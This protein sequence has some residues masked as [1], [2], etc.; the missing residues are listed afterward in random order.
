MRSSKINAE[1]TKYLNTGL[2]RTRTRKWVYI[3]SA[4]FNV[5]CCPPD[6]VDKE[7]SYIC[8]IGKV[9]SPSSFVYKD[10]LTHAFSQAMDK[11][12]E[13]KSVCCCC[14][15]PTA[16]GSCHPFEVYLPNY[17]IILLLKLTCRMEM[18]EQLD[19]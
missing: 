13:E 17:T 9:L 12:L 7:L 2:T 6:E 18:E 5:E 3:T 4:N 15:A 14:L 19:F 16:L 11:K 8:R 1:F 10:V